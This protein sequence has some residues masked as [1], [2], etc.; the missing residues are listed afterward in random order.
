[1]SAFHGA[2]G[3]ETTTSSSSKHNDL[4]ARLMLQAAASWH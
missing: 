1:V 3:A 2:S 4:C